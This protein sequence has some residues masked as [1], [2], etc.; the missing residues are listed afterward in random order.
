MKLSARHRIFKSA[1]RVSSLR[2]HGDERVAVSRIF[3]YFSRVVSASW[4]R[5]ACGKCREKCR[6]IVINR[7]RTRITL[8]SVVVVRRSTA[9][10]RTGIL[11]SEYCTNISQCSVCSYEHHEEATEKLRGG[12]GPEWHQAP[13]EQPWVSDLSLIYLWR[14]FIRIRI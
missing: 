9:R 4:N 6:A 7:E 2:C 5:I 11:A 3:S 13:A 10:D 12:G 1:V 14:I 8:G